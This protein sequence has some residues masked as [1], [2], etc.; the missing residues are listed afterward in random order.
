MRVDHGSLDDAAVWVTDSGS[1]TNGKLEGFLRAE[2]TR[3]IVVLGIPEPP[4]VGDLPG[5]VAVDDS[6]PG[7]LRRALAQIRV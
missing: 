2:P 6:E 7:A 4:G 1:G 5:I 3:R